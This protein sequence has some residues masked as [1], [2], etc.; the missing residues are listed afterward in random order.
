MAGRES[1]GATL[2][3]V[4]PPSAEQIKR[5]AAIKRPYFPSTRG[6]KDSFR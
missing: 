2:L 4:T 3:L 5:D 1:G 6:I